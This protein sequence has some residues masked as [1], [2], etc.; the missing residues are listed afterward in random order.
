MVL[1]HASCVALE[2]KA[3]LLRGA[4]GAGKSDL[5]LRLIE[6]GARLVADDR[7]ALTSSGEMLFAAPPSRIAGLLEVRGIGIVSMAF[8]HRCPVHLVVDLVQPETVERMPQ[9]AAIELYGHRIAH[10]ALAPFEA[11]TPAKISLALSRTAAAG[12]D[13]QAM[14]SV[15]K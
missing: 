4:P 11:S 12:Q 10:V 8:V 6:G 14:R 1:V 13:A 9:A 5:A 2:G 15:G 3:A 7:V